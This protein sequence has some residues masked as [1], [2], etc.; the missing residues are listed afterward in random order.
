MAY[1]GAYHGSPGRTS[2]KA[3]TRGSWR[4]VVV[5]DRVPADVWPRACRPRGALWPSVLEKAFAKAC[6]GYEQMDFV[7]LTDA[8]VILTGQ[9]TFRIE[10][11]R[12]EASA[13]KKLLAALQQQRNF[14]LPWAFVVLG[15]RLFK[16]L[17][18][19]KR[20]GILVTAGILQPEAMPSRDG[21][22]V[23]NDYAAR[24][25][26]H[27]NLYGAE[28]TRLLK[29][30]DE[31]MRGKQYV[32]GDQYT[33]ADMAIWP[34]VGC[35]ADG[36]LFRPAAEFL[37]VKEYKNLSA[38]AGSQTECASSARWPEVRQAAAQHRD[39]G[40][41]GSCVSARNEHPPFRFVA[42]G[43]VTGINGLFTKKHCLPVH[44]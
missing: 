38:W 40:G 7:D 9:S 15:S 12:L 23:P 24:T 20:R 33:I 18:E 21:I 17:C 2:I 10:L 35:L 37:K 27:V 14:C 6:G 43:C 19:Y 25:E 22:F 42:M 16:D 26:C 30:L 13:H 28:T 36:K 39:L 29:V 11:A 31:H 1:H 44:E 32:C 3:E 4:T 5:D 8:L 41:S 34:W